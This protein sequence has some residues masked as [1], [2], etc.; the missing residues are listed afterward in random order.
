MVRR[1]LLLGGA[2]GSAALMLMSAHGCGGDVSPR[3][4]GAPD[5]DVWVQD[6]PVIFPPEDVLPQPRPD[7]EI[8]DANHVPT[9]DDVGRYPGW[10][11]C[12]EGGYCAGKCVGGWCF[13]DMSNNGCP[14]PLVCCKKGGCMT[15]DICEQW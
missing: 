12:C 3:P 13:C 6:E 2:V 1:P 10:S 11:S 9:C 14:W 7:R 5:A 15:A 4:D 8:P